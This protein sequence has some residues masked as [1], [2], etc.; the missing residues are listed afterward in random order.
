MACAAC[1]SNVFHEWLHLTARI[2]KLNAQGIA[3]RTQTTKNRQM[4]KQAKPQ[5]SSWC[6]FISSGCVSPQGHVAAHK[7]LLGSVVNRS[8]K[9]S[10]MIMR[11]S[12]R[13]EQRSLSWGS[14]NNKSEFFR[15]TNFLLQEETPQRKRRAN[16]VRRL[17]DWAMAGYPQDS[18]TGCSSM[19]MS[20]C[21][22]VLC[23]ICYL[24]G[25]FL[26]ALCVDSNGTQ[27]KIS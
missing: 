27:W 17:A 22:H 14:V 18:D 26:L 2:F 24:A 15:E 23:L 11:D 13:A 10:A 3:K 8:W 16:I 6:S 19:F 21:G 25:P 7:K 4:N 5:Y 12:D 9:L 1:C 20:C